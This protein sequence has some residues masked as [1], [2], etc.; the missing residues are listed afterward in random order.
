MIGKLNLVVP[1]YRDSEPTYKQACIDVFT[2]M[3][4]A[5]GEI[6][7]QVRWVFKYKLLK[8]EYTDDDREYLC[9][10]Y[11]KKTEIE[12]SYYYIIFIHDL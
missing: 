8:Q 10:K 3:L 2:S 6:L 5:F 9:R 1:G 12:F 7:F 4:W 11:H